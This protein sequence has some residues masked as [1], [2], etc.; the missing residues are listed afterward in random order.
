MRDEAAVHTAAVPVRACP[1]CRAKRAE[2]LHA[3]RFQLATQSPLPAAYDVV[4]CAE[5]N[6]VYAATPGAA[7]DYERHYADHSRYEDPTIATGGGASAI[8]RARLDVLADRLAGCVPSRARILDIGCGNG[9]LLDALKARGYSNLAGIDPA[10]GCVA[11][12]R[13]RGYPAWE[14]SL[15]RLPGAAG[16]ADLVVLSHV[17]E[18]VLHIRAALA[19]VRS[20]LAP[21]A[22]LYVETPDATRYAGRD[23]VPFYFFDSEHINHFDAESLA[24]AGRLEGYELLHTDEGELMLEGQRRYPEVHAIFRAARHPGSA[25]PQPFTRLKEA[26]RRY[27]AESLARSDDA[28]LAAIVASG[29]PLALWGAGSHA[30]R[31]LERPPLAGAHFLAVVDRDRRKHGLDF[32]GCRIQAPEAG[33]QGVPPDTVVVVAAALAANAIV[34]ECRDTFLLSAH[35]A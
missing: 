17:M 30:Q 19:G 20:R 10:P 6:F 3:M 32:A 5:C 7:S 31:L 33:L 28:V 12:L 1:I 22:R 29:R 23:F 34:A 15:S 9:G 14:G 35:A 27:V 26:V 25:R 4:A 8:D 16:E 18:H 24:A 11:R 2:T 13:A 21:D